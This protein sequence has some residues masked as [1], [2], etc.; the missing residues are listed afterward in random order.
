M[1]D[2]SRKVDEQNRLRKWIKDNMRKQKEQL[3]KQRNLKK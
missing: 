3:L 2:K 1:M